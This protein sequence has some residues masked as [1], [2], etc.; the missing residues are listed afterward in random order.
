RRIMGEMEALVRRSVSDRSFERDMLAHGLAE[1]AM[2]RCELDRFDRARSM[3]QGPD[4]LRYEFWRARIT[5]DVSYVTPRI[6]AEAER[7][8]TRFVRQALEG[9]RAILEHGYC[10][11]G[12]VVPAGTDN[13][14]LE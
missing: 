4:S 3:T 7:D 9:Y 6:A 8:D 10:G 1:A 14:A 12:Q 13:R 5:G 11:A 2:R